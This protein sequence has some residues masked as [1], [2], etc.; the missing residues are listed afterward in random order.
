MEALAGNRESRERESKPAM[1]HPESVARIA[2]ESFG[3]YKRS[4][5]QRK[6]RTGSGWSS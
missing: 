6:L 4:S 1:Y 3:V 5:E 2:I